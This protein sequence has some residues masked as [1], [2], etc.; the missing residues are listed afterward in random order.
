MRIRCV[1][2]VLNIGGRG[3]NLVANIFCC[4]IKIA[5]G[6]IGHFYLPFYKD[7][8]VLPS[9]IIIVSRWIMKFKICIFPF[10]WNACS[11]FLAIFHV[12]PS[13]ILSFHKFPC[14]FFF[15][16]LF[17]L[18]YMNRNCICHSIIHSTEDGSSWGR[19]IL[20]ENIAPCQYHSIQKLNPNCKDLNGSKIE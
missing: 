15:F 7:T 9:V 14:N 10:N 17:I 20:G 2:L 1:V 6:V 11:N 16:L 18:M 5:N 13:K 4:C 8:V 19:K 3:I 12:T